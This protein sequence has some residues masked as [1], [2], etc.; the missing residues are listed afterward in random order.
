MAP[1]AKEYSTGGRRWQGKISSVI[2]W[3]KRLT[4]IKTCLILTKVDCFCA[5]GI[6]SY[7]KDLTNESHHQ[8]RGPAGGRFHRHRL[9]H[10]QQHPLCLRR[11]QG[12]GLPGHPP[13]GLY[14][15]RF[16]PELPDR[17]KESHWLYRPRHL[18]QIFRHH[19]RIGGKLPLHPGLPPHHR[20]HQGEHGA[21][22]DEPSPSHSGPG[23]RS[24]DR[25]HYGRFPPPERFDSRGLSGGAGGPDL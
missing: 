23:G 15:R 24:F 4:E 20:Q 1:A 18:Q 2:S 14:A 3:Q 16:R 13:A 11:H 17:K 19:H 8:R 5:K 12:K 6:L 10:H 25:Q 21:G 22:G 9:P 7:V